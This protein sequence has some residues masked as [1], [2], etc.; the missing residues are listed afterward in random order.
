V[1][2]RRSDFQFLANRI[3]ALASG[4][5]RPSLAQLLNDLSGVC[6]LR[7]IVRVARRCAPPTLI[8]P[9]SNF[10]EQPPENRDRISLPE[11]LKKAKNLLAQANRQHSKLFVQN[12]LRCALIENIDRAGKLLW[13]QK[14]QFHFLLKIHRKFDG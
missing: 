14:E 9:G 4:Q 10:G 6:R 2:S 8:A 7:F 11:K 5:L 1:I 3:N 12:A 13:T